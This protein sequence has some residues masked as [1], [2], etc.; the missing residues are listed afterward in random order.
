MEAFKK[1]IID[2]S[3]LSFFS[4]QKDETFEIEKRLKNNSSFIVNLSGL[5]AVIDLEFETLHVRRLEGAIKENLKSLDI[6]LTELGKVLNAKYITGNTSGSPKAIL[7]LSRK[8]GYFEN[9]NYDEEVMKVI[10]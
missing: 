2:K 9:P 6:F 7:K 5:F 8:F 10:L 1:V 4:L 3:F